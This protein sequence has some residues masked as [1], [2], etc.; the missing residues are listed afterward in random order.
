MCS[1]RILKFYFDYISNNAYIAWTQIHSI[2]ETY[3][4]KLEPVPVLFAGLLNA[5]EQKG[6]A[7]IRGKREWMRKNVLRKAIELGIP[8][9]PPASHPFNP[10]LALRATILEMDDSKRKEL[11]T[12]IFECVWARGV[13]VSQ[14]E[15]M[16]GILLRCGIDEQAAHAELKSDAV[17]L[18]LRNNTDLAVQSGVF[19]VP[20]M[21]I[22]GELFWGYDDFPH[23]IRFL[24]GNDPLAQ[25][26][27]SSWKKVKGSAK[28]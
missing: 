2:A 13:D 27:M 11:I 24:S 18:K 15:T 26:E 6:P 25:V 17:K 23:L 8:L 16:T 12:E 7:E 20:T 28:R 21:V 5:Y 9:S 14:K 19:G 22:E 10:L 3:K 4:L 1:E